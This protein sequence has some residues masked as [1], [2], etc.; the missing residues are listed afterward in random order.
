[1]ILRLFGV[2]E[3]VIMPLT[4]WLDRGNRQRG[5][6]RV[7]IALVYSSFWKKRRGFCRDFY[8]EK[9]L[10]NASLS[11]NLMDDLLPFLDPEVNALG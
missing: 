4:E 11:E 6:R 5:A 2:F 1:V 10:E 7:L 9:E 3:E 8:I